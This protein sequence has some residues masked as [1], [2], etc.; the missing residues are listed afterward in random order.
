LAGVNQMAS[1]ADY[2]YRNETEWLHIIERCR[3]YQRNDP[4]IGQAVRRLVSNVIQTGFTLDVKTGDPELDKELKDHWDQWA[5]DSDRCHSEREFTFAQIERIVLSSTVVD[6][7]VFLLPLKNGSIQPVE[8]HRVRT[9][10]MTTRNVIHGILLDDMARRR[11]YWITKEDLD[12]WR[13][14]TRVGEIERYKATGP[15]GERQVH[16]IYNPYRFSQRRGVSLMAPVSDIIG[17]HDDTQFASLVKQQVAAMICILRS[18]DEGFSPSGKSALGSTSTETDANGYMRTI[19][20]VSAGLDIA[21]AP[22][23]TLEAFAPQIPGPGYLDHTMMLLTFIAINLDMP[24]HMLLLDPSRTNFSGWRGAIDQAR[25]RFREIQQWLV[26]KLHRPI[27]QWKVRQFVARSKRLQRLTDRLAPGAVFAHD[28]NPPS[29]PY[30]EP[31]TDASADLLIMRNGLN[32]PRRIFG[33]RGLEYGTVKTEAIEDLVFA[34]RVAR[35]AAR[36]FNLEAEDDSERISMRELITFPTA[37][38]I[39]VSVSTTGLDQVAQGDPTQ[40]GERLPTPA[41]DEAA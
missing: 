33:S 13:Q 25:L 18:R 12:P 5:G 11:E 1:G 34:F 29:W 15:D 31:M 28:W 8:A 3:D 7:D 27:Y 9:P 32:S 2:H 37:D 41:K 30:L 39:N 38:G 36:K 23:E 14:L 40:S 17:M 6:G 4:I 10:R 35:D 19:E 21:S 22:G 24:I 20:G 26:D 16:H